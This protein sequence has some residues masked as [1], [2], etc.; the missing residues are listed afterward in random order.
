M[1]NNPFV[2]MKW[3][4]EAA[5]LFSVVGMSIFTSITLCE[6]GI[7]RNN[8]NSFIQ[9]LKQRRAI[10]HCGKKRMKSARGSNDVINQW[11]FTTHYKNWH[12][13]HYQNITHSI[14]RKQHDRS[15]INEN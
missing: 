13:K 4:E 2:S 6:H 3:C 12:D 14:N 15:Y 10:E 11:R 5:T 9:I 7:S 8:A 1:A